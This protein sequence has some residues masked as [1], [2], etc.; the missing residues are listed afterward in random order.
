MVAVERGVAPRRSRSRRRRRSGGLTLLFAIL[1]LGAGLWTAYWYAAYRLADYAVQDGGGPLNCR[2]RQ[3]S[4][5]PFNLN[6]T[7]REL[8]AAGDGMTIRAGAIDASAPLYRPG[9]VAASLGGPFAFQAPGFGLYANADWTDADARVDAGLNGVTR[10]AA[11]FSSLNLMLGGPIGEMQIAANRFAGSVAAADTEPNAI[12]LDFATDGL[13]LGPLPSVDGEGTVHFLDA[14]AAIGPDV[15]QLVSSW[16]AAGAHM[17]LEQT[18]VTAGRLTVWAEGP[19]SLEDDGT[20]SGQLTVRYS[21]RDGL[22]DL[23]AAILPGL[24]NAADKLADTIVT[25]SLATDSPAGAR[26]EV[27]LALDHGQVKVG[28]IP[29]PGLALPPLASR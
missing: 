12:R 22:P 16:F 7:C 14:G 18:R 10:A 5:F 27:R 19:L 6:I 23:V 4:G 9:H 21:G 24:R 17:R 28:L 11:D 20:L 2:D 15:G 8:A 13:R 25:M 29:I 3:V 26:Y 1:L